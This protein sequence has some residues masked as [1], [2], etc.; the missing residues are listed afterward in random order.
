MPVLCK[1]CARSWTGFG[2]VEPKPGKSLE[3]WDRQMWLKGGPSCI[4]SIE[5]PTGGR[6]RE[7]RKGQVLQLALAPLSLPFV[8]FHPS[9]PTPEPLWDICSLPPT[10]PPSIRFLGPFPSFFEELGP[11][12]LV[13]TAMKKYSCFSPLRFA[14]RLAKKKSNSS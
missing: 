5:G 11:R 12:T 2:G 14:W 8:I 3:K 4:A 6:G 13:K 10:Y 9:H 1:V 7:R